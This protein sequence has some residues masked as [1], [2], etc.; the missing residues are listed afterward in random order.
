MSQWSTDLKKEHIT[1]YWNVPTEGG[2]DDTPADCLKCCSFR[3][4]AQTCRLQSFVQDTMDIERSSIK[5]PKEIKRTKIKQA[6][7]V[8]YDLYGHCNSLHARMRVK[9]E[10]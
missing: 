9:R 6:V 4:A 1:Y 5:F 10:N 3:I 2:V 7:C 8:G